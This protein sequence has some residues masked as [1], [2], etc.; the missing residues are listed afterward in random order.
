[1][2]PDQ[3][4]SRPAAQKQ[5]PSC[6]TLLPAACP[7]LSS[8]TPMKKSKFDYPHL[9]THWGAGWLPPIPGA[10]MVT[11]RGLGHRAEPGDGPTSGC[12]G[13]AGL[14]GGPWSRGKEADGEELTSVAGSSGQRRGLEAW[15]RCWAGPLPSLDG[16]RSAAG[17]AHRGRGVRGCPAASE[18]GQGPCGSRLACPAALTLR[19]RVSGSATS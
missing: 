15:G 16:V 9:S 11:R 5:C 12:D 17:P 1:M 10:Q 13:R 3:F 8:K 18:G 4:N 19:S 14:P 6:K 2:R 7:F